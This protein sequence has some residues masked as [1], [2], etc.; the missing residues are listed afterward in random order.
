MT[1]R[2]K[3]AM[4]IL[5]VWVATLAWHVKRQYFRPLD[6]LL[7]AAATTLPPGVAYYAVFRGEERVGWAQS[8]VDTL[9]ADGG[10]LIEDRLEARLGGVMDGGPT[11]LETRTRLGPTLALESF[12]VRSRG[13]LGP[14]SARGAVEGDSVLRLEVRRAGGADSMR[15][16]LDGPVVPTSGLA[17][18]LAA[19]RSLAPGDR[20]RLPVF[21]P[22]TLSRRIAEVRVV[23]SERRLFPD[24]ADTDEA[25]RWVVARRDTVSA[26]LVEQEVAGLRLRSWVDEDG[27]LLEADVGGGLRLERTAFELAYYRYRAIR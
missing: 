8:R 17:L 23:S 15:V 22:L 18:R 5:A 7:A 13:V 24:S 16:A 10:F 21:D 9:P 2:G 11:L 20:V 1:G 27:R 19:Q 14:L 3:I 6:E 4:A 25:G 12:V 26:W